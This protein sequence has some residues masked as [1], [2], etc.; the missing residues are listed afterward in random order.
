MLCFNTISIHEINMSKKSIQNPLLFFSALLLSA[1]GYEFIFFVMTVHV[2]DLSKNA[3]SIGI[4][5]TLTFVPRLFSSLLGGVADRF[6]KGVCLSCSALALVI[7]L[8]L[9]SRTSAIEQIYA[10]W[11]VASFFLTFIVN[12]RGSL[13]A[14]IVA[15]EHYASGNALSLALLNG[16]K[17]LGPLLGG[18][19]SMALDIHLLLYFTCF[20]YLLTALTA[21]RIRSATTERRTEPGFLRNAVKGFQFMG[22]N[23]I[24]GQMVAVAFFWRLFLGLQISLFVIYA[25]DFLAC[26]NGQYGVFAALIGVGSIAGSLLGP[27]VSKKTRPSQLIRA[28]LSLHYGSFI[29]LGS[30]RSYSVA[31]L[32]VF[33]SYLVFYATLVGLHSVRDRITCAEIRSSAYGTVTAILTPPAIVSMLVG[34]YLANQFGVERVLTGAGLFALASLPLILAPSRDMQNLFNPIDNRI[35]N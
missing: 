5:T 15:R 12:T 2:Y 13:M 17:L 14:E 19:I 25:K 21:I 8:F 22:E 7:L 26:S 35:D 28:G 6:G 16:A 29:L 31:L 3:L 1:F 34:G 20:I 9:M 30:C 11:F 24:F 32:I 27:L 10:I 18:F 33:M 4:F 23:Q